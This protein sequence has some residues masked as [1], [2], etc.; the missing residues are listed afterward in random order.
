VEGWTSL[1]INAVKMCLYLELTRSY[2]GFQPIKKSPTVQGF[3][4]CVGSLQRWRYTG[5]ED[6]KA[7]GWVTARS[8]HRC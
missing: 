8:I 7:V 1:I 4:D 3:I 6:L 5:G 2:V